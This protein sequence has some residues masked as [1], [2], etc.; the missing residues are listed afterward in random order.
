MTEDTFTKSGHMK[1]HLK[2]RSIGIASV[3]ALA[4][5]GLVMAL[6]AFGVLGEDSDP[7]PEA[8]SRSLRSSIGVSEMPSGIVLPGE[9]CGDA[10]HRPLGELR[11]R[12]PIWPAK[13]SE[14]VVLTDSWNCADTAVL[15]YN[16]VQVSFEAEWGDVDVDKKFRDLANDYG[17]EVSELKGRPA[18]VKRGSDE[19]H[20]QIL[21][22]V[23]GTLVRVIAQN[24]I[25]FDRVSDVAD[26]LALPEVK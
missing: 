4:T 25:P 11:S 9:P 15:L 19:G 6:N 1:N 14:G 8:D 23:D 21:T 7:K 20:S 5:V 12:T 2:R 10:V 13:A 3:A 17:G 16:G 18:W 22:V 26:A 24:K